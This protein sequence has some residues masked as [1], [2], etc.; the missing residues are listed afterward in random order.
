MTVPT[1]VS[2]TAEAAARFDQL[3]QDRKLK[4]I[5]RADL[6]IASIVLAN[7]ATLVSRNL[8]DF[9]QVPGLRVENWAD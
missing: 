2:V 7:Q 6:L 3:R 9:Q 8:K 1:I 5:G 4:K